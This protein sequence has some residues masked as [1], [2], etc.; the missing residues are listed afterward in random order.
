MAIF[1]NVAT[2]TYNNITTTSNVATG[3]ILEVLSVTKTALTATYSDAPVTYVISI[4]NTGTSPFSGLTV[5]D[6]LGG[7]TFN[8]ATRYP[9][10][11]V[12][13]TVLQYVN[14]VLQAAPS[15]SVG[16][17]L[18]FTGVNVPA[19]GSTVL[20]Y[21][22][23]VTEYAPRGSGEGVTN[24]VTVQGNGANSP[25]TASE[26]VTAVTGPRLSITKTVSPA[27][28]SENGTLT[29]TFVI[30]NVGNTAAEAGDSLVVT[31]L[32][33]PLLS[34]ISVTLNGTPLSVGS[35]YSYET[36]TGAFSTVPGVITVPAASFTRDASTGAF[37]TVP[38]YAVLQVS[39]TI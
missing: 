1:T 28:V 18:V 16:P 26:T 3:E 8:G 33:D 14:G 21:A 11:Y 36:S 37:S 9:L 4:T 2:L 30:Q 10:S 29:Y 35:G 20:V 32:F 13:G 22:A 19:G 17:P 5:T 39:G 12:D 25:A 15:V 23:N 7:Y 34:N 6:D 27:T 38:G 31:D 24:T